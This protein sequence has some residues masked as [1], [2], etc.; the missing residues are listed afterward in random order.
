M[1]PEKNRFLSFLRSDWKHKVSIG[2]PK[3]FLSYAL[4]RLSFSSS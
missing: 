3:I 1:K 4:Q 2:I